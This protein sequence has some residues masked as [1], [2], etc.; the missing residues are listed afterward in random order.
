MEKKL[1]VIIPAHRAHGT[2]LQA[3]GSI[4]I[5][6]IAD[7]VRVTIVDDCC[8]EG[9]YEEIVAVFRPVLDVQL[10]RMEKNSGPGL[11]RQKGIDSTACEF[12][13]FLDADDVFYS[14]RA[15]ET[16]LQ[17]IE[18]DDTCM[19]AGGAFW[20]PSYRLK[21]EEL[22]KNRIWVFGKIWRRS[23]TERY[24]IRF[25]GTRANED[26][27]FCQISATLCDNPQEKMLDIGEYIVEYRDN[28]QSITRTNNKQYYYDQSICG[29]IDNLIYTVEHAKKYRHFS[30]EILRQIMSGM[31]MCYAEYI[32]V[33]DGMPALA[34]QAWE[35]CKKYYHRVYKPA[36]GC[37]TDASFR[38][39]YSSCMAYY[40]KL[41]DFKG[42][43]P[44][45][46]IRE[47]MARLRREEYDPDL[48]YEIWE[49]MRKDPET[50][51]MMEYNVA[52]GV[53]PEG[54]TEKPGEEDEAS[55]VQV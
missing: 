6:T 21:A 27:S 37:F 40:F 44:Q 17:K 4:A 9:D 47:F 50:R 32:K 25:N 45:I 14:C 28:D 13:T 35:Y 15:L 55:A 41:T 11:A 26:C 54:Y 34:V 2:L 51:Q 7:R 8:P 3:L 43:I 12:Y 18:K 46:G 24:N 38:A 52:C 36:E 5:Q 10:I 33:L 42:V 20:S 16:L 23:F 49:E 48:I 53:C 22:C 19:C 30:G 29:G 39:M 31:M 1:D